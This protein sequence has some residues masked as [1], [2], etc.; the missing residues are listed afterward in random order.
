MEKT[1]IIKAINQDLAIELPEKI[2]LDELRTTLSSHINELIN[3]DFNRL[4]S[5]LYRIDVSEQKLKY[6][7]KENPEEKAGTIIT[8]LIIER[9]IQKI[10]SREEYNRRNK[11]LSDEDSW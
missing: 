8:D 6:L 5:I 7:I 9:Q 1:T 2:S 10:K 3:K 4:V 11:N